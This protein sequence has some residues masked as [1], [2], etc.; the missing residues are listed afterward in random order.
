MPRRPLG[1][2]PIVAEI[3]EAL[4]RTIIRDED[5]RATLP[6]TNKNDRPAPCRTAPATAPCASLSG[7]STTPDVTDRRTE[8]RAAADPVKLQEIKGVELGKFHVYVINLGIFVCKAVF[9]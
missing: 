8:G 4:A 9:R 6:S 2:N 5:R 7:R 3:I 1:L